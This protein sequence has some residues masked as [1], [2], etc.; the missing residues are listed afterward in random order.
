M[1]AKSAPNVPHGWKRVRLGDVL[2]LEYGVS[3]PDRKRVPGEIP[4]IG[5]AGV[6]GCHNQATNDGPGIVI[7]RKGSIG[8][9]TW[10]AENFVPIDT[11]Y[12]A[13]PIDGKINLRW[14]YHFLSREDL[15]KLNRAT[16][17]PGLNRDDVYSLQRLLPPLPEQRAIAA[18]LDS[19]D[20]AIEGAEAV[21]AATGQLRDS[22]LHDLLTR[23]LLGQHTEFR[24]VPGLGTIPADWEVVR[25][26][27]VLESTTY[28]TNEPLGAQGNVAVLRMNNLQDGKIDL[29]QVRRADLS[30]KES[31][32]L[33]LVPGDIL[34]NRTNSLD[35]VGKVAIVRDLP[36]PISFA[37]YL[38]RLRALE[39]QVNP[40]WLSALLWS[41]SCQSR[42]QRFATPGVSQA[43]I[44]PT[45]L[46][47]LTIPL[48]PLPEQQAIGGVLDG[49]DATLEGAREERDGLELLKESTAN[50][51]LTG[52]VRIGG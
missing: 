26:G 42:I 25:L 31:S 36:E 41:D 28:G 22:L 11:T 5:S 45:S 12:F 37:S 33:N 47:S 43:N 51:L 21:I 46:K 24:D 13:V 10:V 50:S 52:S 1:A 14:A 40:Y 34:F 39:S 38:I 7:G 15:S 6:V 32:E 30:A 16:G 27:D 18:V 29:S 19:I 4:V 20:D 9:V 8:S 49:L 17:I 44:N 3:L 23:G 35:L 2:K 48:P